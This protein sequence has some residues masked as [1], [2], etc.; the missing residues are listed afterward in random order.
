MKAPSK[1]DRQREM[2]EANFV[3]RVTKPKGIVTKLLE[4][5][6]DL[7]PVKWK[8]PGRPRKHATGAARAKAYRAR[9]KGNA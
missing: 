8:K 9:R 4:T 7:P 5:L 6:A 2:R 3:T 1:Y